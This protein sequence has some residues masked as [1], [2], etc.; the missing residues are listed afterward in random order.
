MEQLRKTRDA[1]SSEDELIEDN[2][3]EQLSRSRSGP[4]NDTN[5]ELIVANVTPIDGG[6]SKNSEN[7]SSV[8]V[9]QLEKKEESLTQ[10]IQGKVQ[11]QSTG[12]L[13]MPLWTSCMEELGGKGSK[14]VSKGESNLK[15]KMLKDRGASSRKGNA[16][17]P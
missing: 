5:Q 13:S 15:L 12:M 2:G 1:E 11:V 3:Q 10:R 9:K 6:I 7:A 16:V 4:N 8:K 14:Q 17:Y